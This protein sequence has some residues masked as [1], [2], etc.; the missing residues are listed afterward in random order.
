[1]IFHVAPV[2]ADE[3]AIPGRELLMPFT[4]ASL[5]LYINLTYINFNIH[6]VKHILRKSNFFSAAAS[7]CAY[8]LN[9][10]TLLLLLDLMKRT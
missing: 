1:M 9:G 2:I 6:L 7:R 3:E 5:N 8:M 10:Y 4:Y